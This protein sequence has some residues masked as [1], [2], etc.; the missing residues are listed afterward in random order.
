MGSAYDDLG[1]SA[2][3]LV[4]DLM[5]KDPTQWTR[6][7]VQLC[8]PARPTTMVA[9]G[10]GRRRFEFMLLAG[11][12]KAEMN[13]VDTAWRL[14]APHGWTADNA[15][16]Q[17]HAVYTFRG[18]VARQWR[19]GRLMLAGDA[20]HLMPPFAGQGLC[21]GLRDSAA[22]GWRLDQ[23]LRG[24]ADDSVLDSYG[25]ERS[26]HVRRF[27]DFS[28]MLGGV[29]CI[30][31]AEAAAGRD[32]FL[33][34]PGKQQ[35]DRYPGSSLP[36]SP[37]L[38]A[39]DAHAGELSPQGRVRQGERAGRL[40]EVAGRG[41]VLLGVDAD[42]ATALSAAQRQF[43]DRIGARVLRVVAGAGADSDAQAGAGALQDSDG[44]YRQ[45][46][47]QLRQP[48]VLVRPDFYVFGAGTAPALVDALQDSL[49]GG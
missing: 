12:T 39:G 47:G 9:G 8:D 13:N 25:P 2:D 49:Q 35:E 24:N 7:L 23:L 38:R 41:F 29:I 26:A 15:D 34:G 6:E 14:L 32:A 20:A 16:L 40:D 4:V 18:C 48:A 1:F 44:V 11:E 31:D 33:L 5:P 46:L 3:W 22:L 28:I 37:Q 36:P 19:Q 10:P 27:I 30:L 45:W 43:L 21:A 42:P 17:R